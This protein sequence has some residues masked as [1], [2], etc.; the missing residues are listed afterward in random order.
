[1]FASIEL[2]VLTSFYTGKYNAIETPLSQLLSNPDH[3]CGIP[4]AALG[5]TARIT[6]PSALPWTPGF[7]HLGLDV[8]L[9]HAHHFS[10]RAK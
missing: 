7:I 2:K 8:E 5:S 9:G 10:S 3:P 1:M 4:G 6:V